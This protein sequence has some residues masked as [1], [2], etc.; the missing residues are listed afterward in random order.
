MTQRVHNPVADEDVPVRLTKNFMLAEFH[1]KDGTPVPEEMVEDL[2]KFVENG[3]QLVRT[4]FDA[5]TEIVSAYRTPEHNKRVG[6]A[7]RSYHMYG[8]VPGRPS[9]VFACDMAVRGVEPKV[10]YEAILGLIRL[11]LMKP[12]GVG[13]YSWGVHYDDRGYLVEF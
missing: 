7:K 2:Q 8:H 6:G 13:L 5:R 11:G 4:F 9:D 10:V 3:P 12:G 1:C